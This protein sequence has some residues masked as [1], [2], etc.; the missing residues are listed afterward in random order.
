M[1]LITIK[2]LIDPNNTEYTNSFFKDCHIACEAYLS[3][4]MFIGLRKNGINYQQAE[5]ATK[6]SFLSI[7]DTLKKALILIDKEKGP[8]AVK[9]DNLKIGLKLFTEYSAG[10]RNKLQHGAIEEINDSN[11]LKLIIDINL[12]LIREIEFYLKKYFNLSA[13][14]TPGEWGAK[15]VTTTHKIDDIRKK[16][17]LRP[18]SKIMS[19]EKSIELFSKV[20]WSHEK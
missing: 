3:R 18:G 7:H 2:K 1:H 15:R 17:G 16:F 8:L 9:E 10:Y 14:N 5:E 12:S 13:F 19:F 11:V 20:V 6:E 4:L